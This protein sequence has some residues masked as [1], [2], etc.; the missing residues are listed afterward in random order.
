MKT[1]P[2]LL[3]PVPADRVRWLVHE[4]PSLA[5]LPGRRA[6]VAAEVL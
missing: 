3:P 6:D 5:R 2:D 4:S 1:Q